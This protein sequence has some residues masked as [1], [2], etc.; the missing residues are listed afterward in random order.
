MASLW[1]YTEPVREAQFRFHSTSKKKISASA[2]N[3]SSS[4]VIA[5][6]FLLFQGS[7]FFS[8]Y[9]LP[10]VFFSSL[11]R[12]QTRDSEDNRLN[13]FSYLRRTC[14]LLRNKVEAWLK[15]FFSSYYAL[16]KR[17]RRHIAIAKRKWNNSFDVINDA[18]IGDVKVA[19][20]QKFDIARL[21]NSSTLWLNTRTF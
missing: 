16:C 12:S 10:S 6:M 7:S 20:A 5:K 8:L 19:R 17:M 13:R 11:M 15:P 18:F 14:S 9:V 2:T 4:D 21:C 3:I 1:A